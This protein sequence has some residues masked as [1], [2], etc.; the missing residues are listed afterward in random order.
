[1][2][3]GCPRSDRAAFCPLGF[4]R[5]APTPATAATRS[6]RLAVRLATPHATPPHAT[7]RH[8][9]PRHGTARRDT[10]R[11]AASQRGVS[12]GFA[13][14]RMQPQ[15][16][17]RRRARHDLVPRPRSEPPLSPDVK[18]TRGATLLPCARPG[19]RS[20]W[21][22][23]SHSPDAAPTGA[24]RS[25]STGSP[26]RR[27][28]SRG[29]STSRQTSLRSRCGCHRPS[30]LDRVRRRSLRDGVHGRR[31]RT[32]RVRQHGQ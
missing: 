27:T 20:L 14:A 28:R 31:T 29:R 25:R 16:S 30:M 18:R 17:T 23:S 8:A 19:R 9:T 7:P 5:P 13:R 3:C 12:P 26:R 2:R 4:A 24:S 21:S 15:R 11:H 6:G 32:D 10:A 1:M 22:V